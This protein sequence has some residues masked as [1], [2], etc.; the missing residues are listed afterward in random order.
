MKVSCRAKYAWAQDLS[1][2]A[3]V[4]VKTLEGRVFEPRAL[5]D[6]SLG[7]MP[8]GYQNCVARV[9]HVYKCRCP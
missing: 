5:N 7:G 8:E 9:T 1:T 6:K 2:I 3:I 4:T